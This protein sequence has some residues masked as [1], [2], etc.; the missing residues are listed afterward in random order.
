MLI[1]IIGLVI[2]SR[3]FKSIDVESLFLY[4]ISKLRYTEHFDSW[5]THGIPEVEYP[6]VNC[7]Y[8]TLHLQQ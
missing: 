8:P 2:V 4:H 7:F 6:I 3:R 5:R 1:P